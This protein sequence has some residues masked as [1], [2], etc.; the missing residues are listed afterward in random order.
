MHPLSTPTQPPCLLNWASEIF[1][2]P[3]LL[4]W[5]KK[6]K[7]KNIF[8]LT[9]CHRGSYVPHQDPKMATDIPKVHL[10]FF[11]LR[12]DPFVMLTK[13]RPHLLAEANEF[14]RIQSSCFFPVCPDWN[15]LPFSKSP[16]SISGSPN[17]HELCLAGTGTPGIYSRIW[18]NL[19][20]SSILHL[21]SCRCW[22]PR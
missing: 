11:M 19:L 20:L 6:K 5:F 21:Y 15:L 17:G 1:P 22:K 2:W 16:L 14:S 3:Q 9:R 10:Y 13:P 8:S 18:S 7:K 12:L 4:F